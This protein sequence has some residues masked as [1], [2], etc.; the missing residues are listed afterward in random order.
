MC[1]RCSLLIFPFQRL[2]D[3]R[4]E[5]K[6][7][8]EEERKRQ[9]ELREEEKRKRDEMTKKKE[10]EEENRKKRAAEAFSKFFVPKKKAPDM[11]VID[12]DTSKDSAESFE[13]GSAVKSNFMPFQIRERMKVAPLVRRVLTK[14]QVENFD[15]KFNTSMP[16]ESLYIADI[17]NPLYE[18]GR[19]EKTWPI[20]D[21]DDDDVIAIGELGN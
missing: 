3:Q 2:A 12:D 21:K 6:R 20:D 1:N 7:L 10:V 8:K 15:A 18:K 16:R 19:C 17:K 4:E 9:L 13:S 5:E 14:A 11:A